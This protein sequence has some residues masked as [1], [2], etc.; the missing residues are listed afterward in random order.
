VD[1]AAVDA[2]LAADAAITHVALVH[3]E[4]TS[5][6]LNPVA[7]IAAVIARRDA[8]SCSTR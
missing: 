2:A 3:C 5:G 1:P 7:E 8:A 4:T 6:V